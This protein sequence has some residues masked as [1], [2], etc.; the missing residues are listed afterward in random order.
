MKRSLKTTA[1]FFGGYRRLSQAR[2]VRNAVV[3]PLGDPCA[4]TEKATTATTLR[5]SPSTRGV[6]TQ[7]H[8]SRGSCYTGSRAGL[9]IVLQ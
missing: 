3:N 9:C 5:A 8:M 4:A 6:S 7:Q 1:G 2:S